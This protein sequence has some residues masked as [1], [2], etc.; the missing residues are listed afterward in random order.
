MSNTAGAYKK[1]FIYDSYY[2]HGKVKI[3]DVETN[4]NMGYLGNSFVVRGDLGLTTNPSKAMNIN[5]KAIPGSTGPYYMMAEV[6][7]S[8]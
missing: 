4:A 3:I 2:V 6:S 5:Y 8:L 1:I 7:A